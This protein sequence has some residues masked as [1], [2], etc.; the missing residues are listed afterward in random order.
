[1]SQ[2]NVPKCFLPKTPSKEGQIMMKK[3]CRDS[4]DFFTSTYRD[5]KV[6]CHVNLRENGV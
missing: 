2:I 4:G 3:I 5:F 1:M 6:H